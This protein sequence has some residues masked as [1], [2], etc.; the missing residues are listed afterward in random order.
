MA[1]N[2]RRQL[3]RERQQLDRRKTAQRSGARETQAQQKVAA[4]QLDIARRHRRH[5]QAY[6][7]Y[8]IAIVIAVGHF[9]EHAHAF[10]LMSPGL[11]D[12]LIGWPMAAF[13]ALVG[14]MRY[15]T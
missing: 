2:R 1:S 14:A 9:F 7:L 3:K 8:G 10:Q 5:V 12:L 15:G 13:L 6:V 4:A 11:E